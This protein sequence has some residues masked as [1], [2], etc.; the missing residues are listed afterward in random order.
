MES[1]TYKAMEYK[2]V[3]HQYLGCNYE[4]IYQSDPY[5]DNVEKRY[6]I[7]STITGEILDDAQGYGYKTAQKAYA[8]YAYKNRDRSKDKQ[9]LAK[10]R[11]IQNWLKEHKSFSK[12][13]D[14]IAFEI[15][16]G[17]WGPNDKFD[18]K[19]VQKMLDDNQLEIDFT[20]AELLRVWKSKW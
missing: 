1:K 7:V 3:K 10:K 8:A 5:I 18:S 16:K 19:L 13:M 6:C 4:D 14:E 9:R 2:V 11:H 12:Y 15:A 20:A 17:S